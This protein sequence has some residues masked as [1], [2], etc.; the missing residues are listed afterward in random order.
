MIIPEIYQKAKRPIISFEV[1]PP[2]TEKGMAN[3]RQQLETLVSLK[4]D[5]M[6]VT[7]GA[8]KL[9]PLNGAEATSI[10]GEAVKAPNLSDVNSEEDIRKL[11][12]EGIKRAQENN[13]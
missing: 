3:L 13:N 5:Y 2:K 12:E 10:D 8:I 6:T 4:P 11:I 9:T 1:F 7:F